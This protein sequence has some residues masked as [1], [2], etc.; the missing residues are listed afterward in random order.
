MGRATSL[1]SSHRIG[2]G[3]FPSVLRR[4]IPRSVPE[5]DGK[6]MWDESRTGF[7]ELEA[8]RHPRGASSWGSWLF[9]RLVAHSCS[10]IF[11][12]GRTGSLDNSPPY[13]TGI[14]GATNEARRRLPSLPARERGYSEQRSHR[15]DNLRVETI[16]TG[17]LLLPVLRKLLFP[18]KGSLGTGQLVFLGPQGVPW[19][20]QCP[21]LV[22]R[23][24]SRSPRSQRGSGPTHQP[25][26]HSPS[27]RHPRGSGSD[28]TA[29]LAARALR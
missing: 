3:L 14:P 9:L 13:G 21:T 22:V 6:G 28:T 26:D 2:S 5:A 23:P 27:T 29:P 25:W 24:G 4:C 18:G 1:R 16:D 7:P 19:W 15:F 12:R 17:F 10:R 11:R 20:H 8:N